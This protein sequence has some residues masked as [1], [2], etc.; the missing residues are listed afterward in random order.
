MLSEELKTKL[1]QR[2]K[3]SKMDSFGFAWELTK[4]YAGSANA[5]AKEI[6]P[7]FAELYTLFEEG[8]LLNENK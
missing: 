1:K 5:D 2:V 3:N 8:K 7:L 4:L 6:A